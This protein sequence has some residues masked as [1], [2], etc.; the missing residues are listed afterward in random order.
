M[1]VLRGDHQ[2]ESQNLQTLPKRGGGSVIPKTEKRILFIF[3]RAQFRHGGSK[4]ANLIELRLT[5]N[6]N[7]ARVGGLHM[8]CPDCHFDT[9]DLME[10]GFLLENL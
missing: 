7:F 6:L 9:E 1:S 10:A 3:E 2:K 4:P 8:Q 5:E